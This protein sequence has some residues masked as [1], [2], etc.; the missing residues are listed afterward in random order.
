MLGE[1]N[2][3]VTP[4]EAKYFANRPDLLDPY[5]AAAEAGA[6]WE[7]VAYRILEWGG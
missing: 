2:V 3:F 5:V 4:R 7:A 1:R 6:A